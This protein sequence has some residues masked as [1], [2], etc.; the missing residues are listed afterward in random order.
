MVNFNTDNYRRIRPREVFPVTEIITILYFE[1]SKAF[2]FAGE[3]H[4]F[5]EF[6]YVDKGEI[7]AAADE[8]QCLVKSGEVIFHKPDEFHRLQANGVIAPNVVVVSFEC[9][10]THMDFFR[11]KIFALNVREKQ[12]LAEIIK[13][14]Q[15]AFEKLDADL[16]VKGMKRR[17]NSSICAEHMTKLQIELLLLNIYRR[18][19]NANTNKAISEKNTAIPQYHCDSQLT[20]DII[21]LLI[22]NLHGNLTLLEISKHFGI[23]ISQ[24]KKV[25][26]S[27]TGKSVIEY[28]IQLKIEEAK[29]LIREEDLTFSQ[30]AD[31]L[32]YVSVHYFSKLFKAKTN[33][34][35]T[36]Y[37]LS[38]QAQKNEC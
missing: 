27:H 16:P 36:E 5:W 19:I 1:L 10:G 6:V 2:N 33:M 21:Q 3:S 23:S 14:G 34:T 31:M 9:K 29:R 35:P 15:E 11:D 37:S 18:Y 4:D 32:G 24:I 17:K 7:L 22:K 12:I 28:Y 38:I 30:I 8:K 20:N 13:E 26:R 25:F